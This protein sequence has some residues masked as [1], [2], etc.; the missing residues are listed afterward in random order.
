M[1]IGCMGEGFGTAMILGMGAIGIGV[2][3]ALLLAIFALGKYLFFQ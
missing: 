1:M 3:A 2:L